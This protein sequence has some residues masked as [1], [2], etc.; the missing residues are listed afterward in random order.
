MLELVGAAFRRPGWMLEAIG[1][2]AG[3]RL[4]QP[5]Y[6]GVA[7][8]RSIDDEPG[9]AHVDISRSRTSRVARLAHAVLPGGTKLRSSFANSARAAAITCRCPIGSPASAS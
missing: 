1:D 6:A 4:T 7:H 9:D 3:D 2:A 5:V 8:R